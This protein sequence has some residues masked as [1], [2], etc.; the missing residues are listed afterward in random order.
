MEYGCA[1]L[2]VTRS[3]CMSRQRSVC[4]F[5]PCSAF[6]AFISRSV[7]DGVKSG[8]IK[9]CANLHEMNVRK[10]RSVNIKLTKMAAEI[11]LLL[12]G[13]RIY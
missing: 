5:L 8:A 2:A 11:T 13:V 4:M 3:S 7:A 6:T 12:I 9:N 1:G 10:R